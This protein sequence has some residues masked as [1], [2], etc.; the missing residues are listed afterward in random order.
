MGIIPIQQHREP[1]AEKIFLQAIR[2]KPDFASAHVH[3]GLLYVQTGRRTEAVAQLREGL[4]IDPTRSDASAA[5]VFIWRDEA[6]I[7]ATAGDFE[8]A[9]AFLIDAR[10]LAPENPDVQFAFGMVALKMSLLPD[11][12]EAFQMTLKLRDNDPLPLYGLGR[13]LMGMSKFEDAR[14]QFARYT[15]V[16]PEDA[17]GYCALGMILAAVERSAEARIQLEKSIA[18]TP[19][20]TESYFRLGFWISIR[21]IWIRRRRTSYLHETAGMNAGNVSSMR[22][23]ADLLERRGDSSRAAQLRGE[24]KQLAQRINQNLYVDGKGWW[25]CGQPDGSVT[26]VRHCYDFLSVLDNM[27]EDLGE[28]QKQEMSQFFW[29]ELHS[30][31]WM[32]ALSP[33]DVDAT[34]NIRPDHS[35]LGAYSAWPPAT[36]RGLYQTD[37]SAGVA[38]WVKNLAK[39]GNQGPIGQAH[40]VETA[41]PLEH[42]AA[43]KCPTDAPYLNDWCCI[44]GGGFMDLVIDTIF[45]ANLTLFD[46]IRVRSRLADFDPKA[47]LA[48]LRYQGKNHVISS[49]GVTLSTPSRRTCSESS[50]N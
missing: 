45:G 44:A 41:F 43:N 15:E 38:A 5:L 34:W 28:V 2:R 33:Q 21:R 13:A 7:A 36:A 48:N 32:R 12:I 23:I 46:G 30:D 14:L 9:L 4:R 39:A 35:W 40:F 11:A 3:L 1:E 50:G 19:V 25:K 29:T 17:S 8:K 47:R 24:A 20:Q 18:I 26:E 31:Y 22:F 27:L 16:R 42:G 37:P 10:K 6:W 49:N